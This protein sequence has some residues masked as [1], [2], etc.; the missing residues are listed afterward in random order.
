MATGE[1][2]LKRKGKAAAGAPRCSFCG[3]RVP[4]DAPA[5]GCPFSG[6]TGCPMAEEA[7]ADPL[8]ETI[9]YEPAS[10][11]E[12]DGFPA[13]DDLIAT[14]LGQYRVAEAI[15]RG[16]MGR[17]YRAEHAGLG[18]LCALKVMNPGLVRRYPQVVERFWAEARAV[19][20]LVHPHIVTVH[21]LGTDRGYH[22]IEMEYVPGGVSLR[23]TLI[24]QG[25]LEPIRATN[26]V[27]QVAL[28]L[29]AAH[30]AGLVHRDIKPAN[31]LLT[32][33]GR[34]K[35]A[36]FGLVRRLDD[37]GAAGALAGT[38]TFMAPELFAGAAAGPRSDLYAVGV[39]YFYLLSARLPFASDRL[40][41]LIRLHRR[42]PAPDI[43]LWAPAVPAEAAAILARLLA[44]KPE[45]RYDSA[46]ELAEDLRRVVG[47]LRGTEELVREALEG[48]N[49]FVQHGAPE[50]FRVVLPVPGDR[51]QEVYVE[52]VQG[53]NAERLLQV[54]SVCAPAAPANYEF[55]LRLNAELT[56]GGL[57][58]REV[59]GQPMFVMTRSYARATVTPAD[60]RAAVLEIGRRS[61]WVEQQLTR[62]DV[63]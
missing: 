45:D 18:R 38:P 60:V 50:L 12:L 35:L 32:A 13:V 43:R 55:A 39:M 52:V 11:A 46:E 9:A 36:D 28:A 3:E 40:N 2:V 42:Q 24:R 37:G 7:P 62:D 48:I 22:Y 58:I 15:G 1:R 14:D 59:N 16:Q 30:Q 10:E 57:S 31:V 49:G 51:L 8:G 26:L 47:H 44:K 29:G 20:G 17:V 33:D 41:E 56:I 25:P 54:Y 23:E 6:E 63:F 34:A 21:N 27:R 53:R 61:D 4:E 19:A 5:P